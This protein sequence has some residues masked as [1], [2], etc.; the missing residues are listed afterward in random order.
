MP[1]THFLR[2]PADIE[3]VGKRPVDCHEATDERAEC[4][5]CAHLPVSQ[6]YCSYHGFATIVSTHLFQ[7]RSTDIN[8]R[9]CYWGI[10]TAWPA[11]S[12]VMQ[13]HIIKSAESPFVT[14][15]DVQL[16]Q[17][18]ML[19]LILTDEYCDYWLYA[20]ITIRPS[21]LAISSSTETLL[22]ASPLDYKL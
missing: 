17:M 13:P 22:T 15:Y 7:S 9:K 21:H 12:A 2:L 4:V 5:T 16:L 1:H 10:L 19:R 6:G 8:K 18:L 14:E 3:L 20:S 11:L